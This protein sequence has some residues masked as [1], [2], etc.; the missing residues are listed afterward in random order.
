MAKKTSS[1]YRKP[2]V[3]AVE[4]EA[5]ETD[6]VTE[7]QAVEQ[8]PAPEAPVAAPKPT[9]E[10]LL[11]HIAALEGHIDGLANTDDGMVTRFG[12]T[13]KEGTVISDPFSTQNPVSFKKHPPGLRLSWC[14]PIIRNQIG[15]NGWKP[16]TYDS[17]VGELLDEYLAAPPARLEGAADQDNYVRRGKTSILCTLD[18]GIFLY[19]QLATERKSAERMARQEGGNTVDYV[20]ADGSVVISGE[21]LVPQERPQGGFKFKHEKGERARVGRGEQEVAD[22]IPASDKLANRALHN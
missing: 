17:D 7:V 3:V 20:R 22:L 1:K 8:Q 10:E 9:E 5:P 4:V 15:W 19:R 21:G 16:V 18:E 6:A 2:P 13:L 12:V 11:A 14:N